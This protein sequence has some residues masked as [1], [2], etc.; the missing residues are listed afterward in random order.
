M[1]FSI[2]DVKSMVSMSLNPEANKNLNSKQADN[3]SLNESAYE[4]IE[5]FIIQV[6]K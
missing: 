5:D 1:N 6:T 4:T 2:D 3:K